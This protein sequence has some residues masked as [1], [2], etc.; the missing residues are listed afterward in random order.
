M[1]TSYFLLRFEFWMKASR[2]VGATLTAFEMRT[3]GSSPRSMMS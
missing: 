3:C 2:S 1:P